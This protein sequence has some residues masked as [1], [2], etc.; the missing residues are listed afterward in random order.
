VQLPVPYAKLCCRAAFNCKATHVLCNTILPV[1]ALML[2]DLRL[3]QPQLKSC[4]C[5]FRL[6][7]FSHLEGHVG[8]L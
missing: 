8:R 7:S 5:V 6:G 1:C 3:K 2:P 4:F